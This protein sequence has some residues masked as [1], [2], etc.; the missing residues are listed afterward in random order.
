MLERF[1]AGERALGDLQGEYFATVMF[2]ETYAQR[3]GIITRQDNPSFQPTTVDEW[4]ISG[5]HFYVGNPLNKSP[6]TSC[7]A[8]THYDDIDL[9]EIP[10]DYLPRAVLS[11][12]RPRW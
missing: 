8:N 1:A 2:D 4:V 10:E 5:P 12:R 3:D 9:T 11:P 6:R 7:L